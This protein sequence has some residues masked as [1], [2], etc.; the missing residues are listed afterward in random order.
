MS[1]HV[2]DASLLEKPIER[3]KEFIDLAT[4]PRAPTS[5][6]IILESQELINFAKNASCSYYP[7]FRIWAARIF[8][9]AGNVN[10][11]S[12]IILEFWDQI[13][14]SGRKSVE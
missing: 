2:E 1:L 10:S 7:V 11:I 13:R 8:S 6:V 5:M 4:K 14:I 12:K 9:S 3:R